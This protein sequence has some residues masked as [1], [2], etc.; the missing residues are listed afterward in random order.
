MQF[1]G[2]RY[3]SG[4]LGDAS[5]G[6]IQSEHYHRYLF[7]LRFCVGK[8]VL[9]IASGE[10]YG[11][12]CLG[13]VASS[14]VGI[15]ANIDAVDFA[16]QNYL[17]DRVSF[18]NGTAQ[19][20]PIADASIDVVISFET[21][22]HFTEHE[23]FATEVRRV[24][25]PGGL[26]VISSPNRTVYSEEA[27]YHNAWHLRELDR[28]E[29][30]NYLVGSFAHVRL[31]AQR[32]LIGSV[33]AV[34]DDQ[35]D[36]RP[37]GFILRG[38]GIFHR[39]EG[40]P[41]PPFFLALASNEA[42]REAGPS[43]LQNPALLQH[44]DAQRQHAADLAAET[45]NKLA[46]S[47]AEVDA[48]SA[49]VANY[50]TQV[51]SYT[52]QVAALS[53]ELESVKL[54][55]AAGKAAEADFIL[56]LEKVRGQLA[57][58]R[59][60][61]RLADQ[62][63]TQRVEMLRQELT[64]S[65]RRN[66]EL[67]AESLSLRSERDHYALHFNAITQSTA[68]KA[69]LPV[70]MV[71]AT[72]SSGMRQGLRSAARTGWRLTGLK[73]RGLATAAKGTPVSTPK[74]A[75]GSLVLPAP[76]IS[77]ANE[78]RPS[79]VQRTQNPAWTEPNERPD[80]VRLRGHRSTAGIAVVA[81]VFY[82]D[83]WPEM[84]EAIRNV[85]EPFDLF[86][87]LVTGA[88]DSLAP[89]IRDQFPNAFV[90]C[91]D[92]HGR[93]IFPFL[94]LAR[95]G[96][97]FDYEF[98]CKIHSKRS[99][100]REGGDEWRRHL[101]NGILGTPAQVQSI[102]TVMR[103][104]PDLGIVVADGQIFGGRTFWIS[105]EE[106]S[107]ELFRDIGLNSSAFERDFV[108][109][110]MYWIRPLIL[111]AINAL[112]LGYDDFEP[113][114]LSN[115]GY[116]AHTV[117]RL[118][119]IVCHDAGMRAAESGD[120]GSPRVLAGGPKVHVIAN[121]L[122]QFHPVPENDQWWGRG[123]TEWSNVTKAL[124]LFQGHRQPRL[125]TDLGFYDLRLPE[126]RA[127]QA[128]LARLHGVTAFS[129]YYYWFNGRRL[130]NHP[131]EAM[132][133]SGEPD[134]PFMLCWANEP[135]T[136]NWDGLSKEVLLSQDYAPGWEQAFAADVAPLMRDPRYLQLNGKPM[137]ALY[138]V[139]HFPDIAGSITRLRNAFSDEG[140]PNIHLLGGWVQIGDDKPLPP[141]AGDLG[142]DA[143]FEF[144]PHGIP[145]QPLDIPLAE[146]T[147][148]FD[149]HVYDYGATVDAVL[150]QLAA[151]QL[152]F[153]YR[154]VMMGWDNTARRGNKSFVFQGATPA[155]F[156]RWLRT[157]LQTARA[158]AGDQETAVFINAWNE[159]AEG[160][161]LEPDR[162]FGTGWLEAVASATAVLGNEPEL[163]DPK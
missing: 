150:D 57:E 125:P 51:A 60:I 82:A 114:P 151:G 55:T 85:T 19:R 12:H 41:H 161:Y 38:D 103:S 102:L 147:P 153:R 88:T 37:E 137:L 132:V 17:T 42:L 98:I 154:G 141:I 77:K 74:L 148:D 54:Q 121:Y 46:R 101:I 73:R 131:I 159:W 163:P 20:I 129:Y 47:S 29:F 72:L 65:R 138:R 71:A 145:T 1:D 92:N 28:S 67:A 133:A 21:L 39:T 81:H 58:Q 64:A 90:L 27:G 8:D 48:Y 56:E 156:R 144:P 97:L 25:R 30:L 10:G 130:L 124:P 31:F 112:N 79:D 107:R 152:G 44:L 76:E 63:T 108:G 135:W 5:S 123:F 49:Q 126:N 6:D 3:V 61:G 66:E 146:R 120:L 149:A 100:Y 36:G 23:A 127:A 116:T 117:E 22:E 95:T 128:D 35:S 134:F 16:N 115:D 155:N 26:L 53:A 99:L 33:I 32:P 113:E 18:K 80:F 142:L 7:A 136:R 104:D 13:Q 9:D 59:K 75:D 70:R 69:T 83:L 158:E 122:P 91:V 86:V 14:V 87:T 84:A 45:S 52:A 15:D 139:A 143:Y 89:A 68:W 94:A 93:D 78:Q 111:R 34:D 96:A 50:A 162:D 11:S 110:S 160:T 105:N 62:P 109:G 119:S 43:M 40:V 2:E 4:L 24:L 106:R 140:F 118:F 157:T